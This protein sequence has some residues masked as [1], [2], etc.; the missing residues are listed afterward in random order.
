MGRETI[1]VFV[2]PLQMLELDEPWTDHVVDNALT[3]DVFLQF[4]CIPA[5]ASDTKSLGIRYKEISI[6]R[7][8]LFAPPD[9][10][11]I[12]ERLVWPLRHAKAAYVVGNYLA[13]IALAGVVAEMTALLLW[14]VFGNSR[15]EHSAKVTK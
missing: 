11:T 5:V 9:E 2:N 7:V 6:E 1:R 3:P 13:T 12:M 8:R 4:L 10:A 15:L 14:D